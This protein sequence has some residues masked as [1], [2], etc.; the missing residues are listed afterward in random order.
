[1]VR[2]N[3]L[4]ML[5]ICHLKVFC[6]KIKLGEDTMCGRYTL[7]VQMDEVAERFLC[8]KA[9]QDEST[10]NV[11]STQIMPIVLE[12]NGQRQ[13]EMMQWGLVPFWP[14]TGVWAASLL[15]PGNP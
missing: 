11:A 14:K 4:F 3:A 15:M 9:N 1:M 8:P 2:G 10:Y 12:R 7:A 13:L 5:S 6:K